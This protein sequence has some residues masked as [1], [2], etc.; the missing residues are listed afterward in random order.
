VRLNLLRHRGKTHLTAGQ[1]RDLRP[2]GGEQAGRGPADPATGSGYHDD[3]LPMSMPDHGTWLPRMTG[4]E[5]G[6]GPAMSVNPIQMQKFLGGVDYPVDKKT[7][8]EY[9]RQKGAD[10]KVINTLQSLPLDRFNSPNDISEAI[11]K[12]R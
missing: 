1:Q 11:G 9:A 3:L 10:E 5:P 8:V 7:L 2:A 6:T 4:P 12:I